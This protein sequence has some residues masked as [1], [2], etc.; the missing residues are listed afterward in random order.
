MTLQS[1]SAGGVVLNL[2]GQI[3][4]TNQH[5]DSWSLPKGHVEE[6]EDALVAA[7]REIAEET[8]ITELKLVRKLCSYTRYRIGKNGRGENTT[9]RKKITLYLFA[10]TQIA[11]K[12]TDPHNPE[13]R[14]VNPAQAAEMLTHP[15]DRKKFVALWKTGKLAIK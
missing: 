11:L 7:Q 3:V 2:K 5:G 12:P 8:G 6:G 9:E 4:L 10:T 1:H 14:W 13:A 15:V